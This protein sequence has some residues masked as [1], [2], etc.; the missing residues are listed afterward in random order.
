MLFPMILKKS[1]SAIM[2]VHKDIVHM[3][4]PGAV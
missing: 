4:Y 2:D 1:K 3:S